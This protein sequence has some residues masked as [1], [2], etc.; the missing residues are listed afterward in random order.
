MIGQK[1]SPGR[2]RA[3]FLSSL[4]CAAALLG[5]QAPARAADG[6]RT[7]VPVGH[8]IGIK[9][10][11]EGVVV[12]GLAEVESGDGTAAPGAACGLKVGDVIEEANGSAVESS[13]QFAAMLQCGGTV[14]LGVSRD[15][16]DLILAAEPALGPDGTYRLGAWIRDSMAG[17]GTVTFYDPA[18]GAFGAL[19]HGITDSDTGLLMPLGDGAVMD[20]SVKAVKKGASGDPGEL[21]GSFNLTE[22]MGTLW[23]NTDRGI[24]GVLDRCDF[25]LGQAVPVAS[26]GQVHTGPAV[27]L[28]NISGDAVETFDVELVRVV[29]GSGTQNLLIQVTDPELI[30]RTGGIVQGM[31]GSP[32]LQGGQLVGAVTHVMIDDPTKGYGILIENMLEQAEKAEP[33]LG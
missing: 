18:T 11:S 23:A 29:E 21:R 3:F 22:D 33:T 5:L 30:A 24:F 4:L 16:A 10:F 25:T 27:I 28:S 13:E 26:A 19:G 2:G 14:E 12:V 31:S 6:G 15:G 1:R 20:A 8:T 32:I 9:L 7:L 17:I